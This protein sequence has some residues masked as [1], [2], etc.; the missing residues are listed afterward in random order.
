M[1]ALSKIDELDNDQLKK[2]KDLGFIPYSEKRLIDECENKKRKPNISKAAFRITG[3]ST[4][5]PGT[6]PWMVAILRKP[7]CAL[8]DEA[9]Q[10]GG[11]LINNQWIITTAHCFPGRT[12]KSPESF[13]IKI[14]DFY[15]RGIEKWCDYGE[16]LAYRKNNTLYSQFESETEAEVEE[17][18]IHPKFRVRTIYRSRMG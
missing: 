15:N 3:G 2:F 11:S 16:N 18:I 4:V 5:T 1:K 13:L 9:H 14:G 10:C 6:Q 8:I 7:R 17:I 12:S